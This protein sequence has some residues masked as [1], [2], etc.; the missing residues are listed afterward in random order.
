[1]EQTH[2]H[3]LAG[4][5]SPARP[6]I[7]SHA[8]GKLYV[9]AVRNDGQVAYS[10]IRK[11]GAGWAPWSVVNDGSSSTLPAATSTP[12]V[13]RRGKDDHLYLFCRGVD[14]NL[15]VTSRHMHQD[16]SAWKKLTA[17]NSVQGRASV[18]FTGDPWFCHVV[19]LGPSD[20]VRYRR[21]DASWS[22]VGSSQW[23]NAREA[24]LGSDSSGEILVA[25][26]STTDRLSLARQSF[27]WS[28]TWQPVLTKHGLGISEPCFGL[29][30]I[31]H[32]AEGLH[33]LYATRALQ[34]DI[35]GTFTYTLAHTRVPTHRYFDGHFRVVR[36]YSIAGDRHPQSTLVLHRDKLVAG[37]ADEHGDI[38]AAWL[39]TSDPDTPWIG[40]ETVAGG[41]SPGQPGLAALNFWRYLTQ[42]EKLDPNFGNDL[43]AVVSG[44]TS[45]SIW[46]ANFSRALAT[47]H[48]TFIGHAV[49]WCTN[50]SGTIGSCPPVA[51][52]PD[53]T[54]VP[55][56]SEIT[57]GS[58][59]L[60]FWLMREICP[61]VMQYEGTP[62]ASYM[63]W[64]H[65]DLL[66]NRSA[67]I[68]PHVNVDYDMTHR[69]W[70]HEMLHRLATSMALWDDDITAHH[71]NPNL[72]TD[73][74]SDH[75]VQAA[76]TL[77]REATNPSKNC[78]LGSDGNRCRGFTCDAP[79]GS[80]AEKYDVGSCQHSFIELV[81]RYVADGDALRE[82]VVSDLRA[83]V[84]LLRRKY[85]WV[86][87]F[88]FRGVEFG[89][90]GIPI[91][92][93]HV[94]NKHSRKSLDVTSW[95]LDDNGD[96]Q[97]YQLHGGDNQRWRL[98]PKSH[99]H[100]Q[101]M[102][103]HSGKCLDVAGISDADGAAIQQYA[104]HDGANQQ[105]AL[106]PDN[107]GYYELVARHSGKCLEVAGW[108]MADKG[109]VA[110]YHRH[111]GDNQ[112]WELASA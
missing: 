16:W 22:L 69:A 108:S 93:V 26:L 76:T 59:T 46:F 23:T 5:N 14:D 84:D 27:P 21:F 10:S 39:D 102:A 98:V 104:P 40:G 42:P 83:G 66:P 56:Y 28:S 29:S 73:L 86:R 77:F 92:P 15:Y 41:R 58:M 72:M 38:R 94:V 50:Y 36:K 2:W 8:D 78:E 110:Q 106:V 71:P 70:Q 32:F 81:Q 45:D 101:L 37:F 64:L 47:G 49:D 96:V 82:I 109:A 61:R 100:Y 97:Q 67:Y 24:E 18:V 4:C 9:V 43:F 95:S 35:S 34:D 112:K 12:S 13:L 44:V 75:L 85:D 99:G 87:R 79:A 19:H 11:D 57:Y 88:I 65:T 80:G 52:L 62:K 90:N 111:G 25:L 6:A 68:G 3:R 91:H 17:D 74:F 31:V 105:W 63:T 51:G 103:M 89:R 107:Y 48:L 55:E 60:P 30:N 54:E 7:S 1:M 33:L 53:A 20:T